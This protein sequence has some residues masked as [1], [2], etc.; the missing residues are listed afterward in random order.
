MNA[1]TLSKLDVIKKIALFADLGEIEIR[2]ILKNSLILKCKKGKTLFCR[3]EKSL[4]LYVVLSGVLKIFISDSEGE[5]TVLQIADFGKS[6]NDIFSK[7]FQSNAQALE[8]SSLLAI[9]LLDAREFQLK[10]GCHHR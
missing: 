2:E 7:N 6:L 5:E 1:S 10:F 3:E 4:N 8:D 9:P